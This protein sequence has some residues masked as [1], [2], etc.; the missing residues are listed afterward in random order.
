M[1]ASIA[2][3]LL[4]ALLVGALVGGLGHRSLAAARRVVR[5]AERDLARLRES[6]LSSDP[7]PVRQRVRQ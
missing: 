5:A 1:D 6:D 4:A 2:A 3:P 7:Y